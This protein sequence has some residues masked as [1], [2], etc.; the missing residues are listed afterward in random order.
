MLKSR[1]KWGLVQNHKLTGPLYASAHRAGPDA[2]EFIPVGEPYREQVARLLKKA[3][4]PDAAHTL[5][6]TGYMEDALLNVVFPAPSI[7]S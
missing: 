6:K 2:V 1:S 7:T 3:G 5:R 4:L